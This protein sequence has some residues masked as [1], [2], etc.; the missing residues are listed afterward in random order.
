M[1]DEGELR[2]LLN[3]VED[4]SERVRPL[5]IKLRDIAKEIED[6]LR[7]A[8][9]IRVS[10][11]RKVVNRGDKRY[12]YDYF[13]VKIGTRWIYVPATEKE[14]ISVFERAS[15][16]ISNLSIILRAINKL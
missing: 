6:V 10:R 12:I 11:K 2:D 9:E 5:L 8:P 3:L 13:E 15:R 7:G 14:V 4:F 1:G 16:L